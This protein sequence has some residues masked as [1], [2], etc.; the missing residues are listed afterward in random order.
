MLRALCIGLLLWPGFLLQGQNQLDDQGR[1]T[2]PWKVEYPNGMTQYEGEFVEGRPVGE[3]LR[4]YEN[5][6]L[7]ARILFDA[8]SSRSYAY[9][10]Y[11]DGRPAAEGIYV[12][13]L[14]DSVWTYYSEFDAS[15]RIREPY[16]MGELQGPSQRFYPDGQVSEEVDWKGNIKDGSWKHYYL[17]GTLRLSGQYEKGL[18]QGTYEV[19]YPDGTIEIRGE[20]LDNKSHGNWRFYDESG[21]EVYAIEYRNGSPADMEKYEL[22]MQDSLLK[23]F[24][25]PVEPEFFR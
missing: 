23:K 24:D 15:V 14:K 6:G 18:L 5:G 8:A 10:F 21:Q 3:M 17:N 1:K 25:A 12:D 2:G 9:L 11:S 7:R 4:Y 13:Q 20:Y 19:Y 22:W 16:V